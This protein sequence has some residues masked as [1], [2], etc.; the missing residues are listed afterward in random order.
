MGTIGSGNHFIEIQIVDKI[1]DKDIAN[2]LGIY[3]E[4]QVT[5]LIHTGSRGF[6]HQIAS[7]YIDLGLKKYVIICLL[8]HAKFAAA[9]IDFQ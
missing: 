7:D 5:V 6:G 4:G 2:K 3:E 9:L 1:F 8:F